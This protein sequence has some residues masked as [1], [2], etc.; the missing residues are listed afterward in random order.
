MM[1]ASVTGDVK[2]DH[3]LKVGTKQFQND[4]INIATNSKSTKVNISLQFFL[5]VDCISDKGLQFKYSVQMLVVLSVV[6]L[7]I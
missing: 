2:F 1:S 3:L 5:P 4:Y 7:G 6:V